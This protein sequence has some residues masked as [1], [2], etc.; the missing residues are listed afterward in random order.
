MPRLLVGLAWCVA[1][2]AQFVQVI[3]SVS[4]GQGLRACEPPGKCGRLGVTCKE[5]CF[6]K[7][8]G[9]K[10]M[11]F[12]NRR[13]AYCKVLDPIGRA[14]GIPSLSLVESGCQS[15]RALLQM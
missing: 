12:D 11:V 6:V 10:C 13:H 3:G 14:V 2:A 5:L 9:Y 8:A 7:V 4:C 15:L 1:R